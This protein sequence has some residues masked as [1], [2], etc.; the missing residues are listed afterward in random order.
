M[1][2]GDDRS[3]DDAICELPQGALIRRLGLFGPPEVATLNRRWSP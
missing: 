2:L 3:N 1:W